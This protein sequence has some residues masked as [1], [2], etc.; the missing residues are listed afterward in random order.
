MTYRIGLFDPAFRPEGHFIPFDRYL[1]EVLETQEIEVTLIDQDGQ[2]QSAFEALPGTYRYLRLSPVPASSRFL[3]GKAGRLVSR[4]LFWRRAFAAM[5]AAGLDMVLFT[6]DARDILMC[7]PSLP[8]PYAAIILYPY[9]YLKKGSRSLSSLTQAFLYR[10]FL[11]RARARFSTNEPPILS[12]I[13]DLIGMHD[14]TWIPD[15]PATERPPLPGAPEPDTFLT[16]GTIS[17]SKNHLFVLDAMER[18]NLPYPYVIA[19]KPLDDTG[20]AVE[21]RVKSLGQ[22]SDLTV[23]GRF[24]YLDEAEY[25]DLM[26]AAAFLVFPY[27]LMRGNISSQVLHDAFSTGTPIIAP[28]I[29]PFRWYVERYGI[30][31]L[32]KEGDATSFADTMHAAHA[33][34]RSSFTAGFERLRADHSIDTIRATALGALMPVLAESRRG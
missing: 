31:L 21:E 34:G 9:A 5:K 6:A 24:G 22:R 28:D 23:S 16:I 4:Y 13:E 17:K 32:Y 11:A 25:M 8:L 20:S 33:A 26:Q 15:L 30:G 14:V 10:R 29:E 1:A 12:G 18:A 2:L 7:A 27:D 19:G 3:P